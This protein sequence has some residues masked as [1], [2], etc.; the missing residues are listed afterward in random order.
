MVLF[1]KG[2]NSLKNLKCIYISQNPVSTD[3]DAINALQAQFPDAEIVCN[4]E[5]SRGGF[6]DTKRSVHVDSIFKGRIYMEED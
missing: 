2:T 3:Q 6:A 1:I 4:R 5:S